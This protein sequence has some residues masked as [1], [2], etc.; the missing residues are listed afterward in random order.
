MN[1]PS[2][3]L[4]LIAAL[5][6]P[7]STAAAVPPALL[8]ATI[9]G[10]TCQGKLVAQ[11]DEFCWLMGRDG[12]LERLEIDRIEKI[13]V[14]AP[15]FRSYSPAESRDLLR[16]EYGKQFDVVGTEHYLICASPVDASKYARVFE[17]IYRS[18][19]LYFSRRGFRISEPEFP[20]IAVVFPSQ[21]EFVQQCRRDA[22]RGG[23]GLLGYYHPDSN[24]VA[25]F[26]TGVSK[27]ADTGTRSLTEGLFSKTFGRP[28]G[29][30]A[31]TQLFGLGSPARD[32]AA[33]RPH[34]GEIDADLSDT[35]VH[36]AAHQVAFNT[37]LHSR[38]GPNPKWIVEGLATA[39]EVPAMHNSVATDTAKD[40]INQ[41]RFTWFTNFAQTRRRPKSLADFVAQDQMFASAGQD[42]Y[43]QGWA[44]T[45]F[46][47]ETRAGK[48]TRYLQRIAAREPL[49]PCSAE[50]RVADFRNAFGNDLDQIEVEFLRFMERLK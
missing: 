6:S 19:Y 20:L 12:R 5:L 18:V 23:P 45:F 25:L 28:A 46:L 3:C 27:T 11:D 14:E 4:V 38:I 1:R 16:R 9:K 44:L 29:E 48:F 47:L 30:Q 26:D 40:R 49:S 8:K 39:F 15:L 13:E 7:A 33:A 21:A 42:A 43:A 10:A 34:A 36:E 24:R 37:G 2:T 22:V 31:G 32:A 35:I 41:G 17:E 50:E